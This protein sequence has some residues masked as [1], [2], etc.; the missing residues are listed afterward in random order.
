MKENPFGGRLDPPPPLGNR[1]VEFL[2]LNKVNFAKAER[3]K[4]KKDGRVLPIFRLEISDPTEAEALVSQNLVCHVTGIVY[5]VEE[6]RAPI[7][8]MQCYNCQCFGH[9]AKTCRSKQKCLICR[10]NHSHKGCPS[11]ES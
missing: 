3:L 9:S 1:R 4:S 6:F 11:R 2:D 5:K 8:I 10:G 7:S